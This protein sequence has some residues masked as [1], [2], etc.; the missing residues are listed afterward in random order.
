MNATMAQTI[1]ITD[2]IREA[3]SRINQLQEDVLSQQAGDCRAVHTLANNTTFAGERYPYITIYLHKETDDGDN[4]K[5][6]TIN[7]DVTAAEL[8]RFFHE[9]S[10]YI[11]HQI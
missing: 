10:E 7:H 2:V 11:N 5:G 8:E 6:W 3:L 1:H 4:C 9:A